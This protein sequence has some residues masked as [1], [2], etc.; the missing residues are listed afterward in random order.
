MRTQL[1]LAVG[2]TV[3]ATALAFVTGIAFPAAASANQLCEQV[4][5]T[6]NFTS[7]LETPMTCVQTGLPV[8]CS[9]PSVGLDPAIH[10]VY[11]T[12]CV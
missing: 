4:G 2:T 10:N 6:T 11:A 7:P 3:A 8:V 9:S 12:V 5:A 1:R